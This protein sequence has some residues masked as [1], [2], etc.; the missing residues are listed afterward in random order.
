MMAV[1]PVKTKQA[2]ETVMIGAPENEGGTRSYTVRIGGEEAMPFLFYQ[3]KIPN[4][5]VI[6]YE[7]WDVKPN[8]WNVFLENEYTEVWNDPITW[9]KY[10]VEEKGAKLLFI[11]LMSTHPDYEDYPT[12]YIKERFRKILDKV[13][14]P[15]VVTGCGI[16]EID[17]IVLPAIAEVGEGEKLLIGN[18]TQENFREITKACIKYGHSLITESPIDINI[19]KQM[20][21][22]VQDEGLPAD[23]IVM[24]ATTGALGYGIEYAYSIMEKTRQ[25]GL[26]GDRYMNK[27]QIAFVGQEVWKTKEASQSSQAGITWET[28]TGIAYLQSG[29][30]IIVVRHPGTVE[31]LN[32]YIDS[33]F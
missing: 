25:L 20:N 15:L 24:Y 7:I 23:R 1:T 10:L 11:K 22:L 17:R 30:D 14:I 31:R 13:K 26:E 6:A 16:Q 29:G 19:A 5:P 4:R 3:G 32:E 27:P 12:K 28:L 8:N 18:A 33:L 9:A 21:I 2:V